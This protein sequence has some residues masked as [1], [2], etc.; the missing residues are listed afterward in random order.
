VKSQH[1]SSAVEDAGSP[2]EESQ[3]NVDSGISNSFEEQSQDN[4]L[5]LGIRTSLG[6]PLQIVQPSPVSGIQ[7]NALNS[8]SNQC[9]C[10]TFLSRGI[11][12][13]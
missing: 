5:D 8:A 4:S 2:Q 1:S 10:R 11:L 13:K 9:E 7:A 3:G 6:G 12:T